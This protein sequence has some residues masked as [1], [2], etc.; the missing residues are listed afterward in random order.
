MSLKLG[1]FGQ[2]LQFSKPEAMTKWGQMVARMT[3]KQPVKPR[4][5]VACKKL[6]NKR[7]VLQAPSLTTT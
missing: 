2:M 1:R 7:Q 4:M 5:N 6:K 3:R